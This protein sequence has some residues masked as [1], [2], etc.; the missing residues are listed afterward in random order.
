M[1]KTFLILT[2]K[3][4]G[5]TLSLP[6]K[7]LTIGRDPAADLRINSVEVSRLHCQLL[8][9]DDQV[10]LKDLGS[11]NGTFLNGEAIFS[12]AEMNP[13]DTLHVGA[14]VFELQGKKKSDE[15]RPRKVRKPP[16]ARAAPPTA[17]DDDVIDWLAEEEEEPFEDHDTTIV[18]NS[19]AQ[20]MGMS[21][22][23]PLRPR[24]NN[25]QLKPVD[26]GT[27]AAEAAEVIKKYW[28]E[29]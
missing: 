26:P 22:E 3:H 18:T 20:S 10:V 12:E 2:G 9:R 21:D 11:R 7:G 5:K 8:V 19:E 25:F 23:S 16:A 6:E 29:R 4:K 15:G 13:G 14:V 17:S 1:K 28:S 27:H 24:M